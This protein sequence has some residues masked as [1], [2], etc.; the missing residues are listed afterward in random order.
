MTHGVMPVDNPLPS[1]ARSP[2]GIDE[3]PSGTRSALDPNS[4]PRFTRLRGL[5]PPNP[6]KGASALTNVGAYGQRSAV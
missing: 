6:P 5:R 2:M 1:N 4:G 3:S